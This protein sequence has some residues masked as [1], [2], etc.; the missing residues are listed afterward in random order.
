MGNGVLHSKHQKRAKPTP[1]SPLHSRVGGR[2][3]KGEGSPFH[4]STC[5]PSARAPQVP[6]PQPKGQ[7]R[8]RKGAP[9]L[10]AR[11]P[12][13]LNCTLLLGSSQV[14]PAPSPPGPLPPSS[15]PPSPLPAAPTK[16]PASARARPSQVAR[17]ATPPPA[18]PLP[19][20]ARHAARSAPGTGAS[21]AS[22]RARGGREAGRR[23]PATPRGR[24]LTPHPSATPPPRC[25]RRGPL[26]RRP[27]LEE[28]SI[29]SALGPKLY[30]WEKPA[31]PPLIAQGKKP[32]PA[33]P[34]AQELGNGTPTPPQRKPHRVAVTHG[35]G[36]AG[37][38][39]SFA[40]SCRL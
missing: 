8:R 29:P 32:A 7:R 33:H 38:F 20:P 36:A 18:S 26:G 27:P 17:A 10:P 31:P 40:P 15:Q 13:P 34:A 4:P 39:P 12:L 6:P 3:A 9:P 19:A 37:I 21:A 11:S 23:V 24:G 22:R 1:P 28:R 16:V 25:R 5:T 2:E 35:P 30:P 14:P